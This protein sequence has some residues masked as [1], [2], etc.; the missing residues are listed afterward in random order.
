MRWTL[1]TA[2]ILSLVACNPDPPV[3]ED[4]ETLPNGQTAGETWIPVGGTGGGSGGGGDVDE[5]GIPD[6]SWIN[7]GPSDDFV[8]LPSN[9]IA[10]GD[11]STNQIVVR[12]LPG[13]TIA[14]LSLAAA[15]LDLE[16]DEANNLLYATLSGS[17]NI[18]RADLDD[19][20]AT[21]IPLPRIAS[22]IAVGNGGRVFVAM[23]GDW[24]YEGPIAVIDGPTGSVINTQDLDVPNLIAFDRPGNRLIAGHRGLSPSSLHRYSFDPATDLF[25]FLEEL[26]SA[27]S[28]GQDLTVSPD[29]QRIAFACG[30]GNAG[31]YTIVDF[32]T[33][34]LAVTFGEWN[35]DAY[36]SAARFSPNSSR[37]VATNSFSILVYDV[38][39]HVL[40]AEIDADTTG[41]SYTSL[42][43]VGY[44][45]GGDYVYA[46]TD[47]GF[48]E[49]S[50]RL[51]FYQ[52]GP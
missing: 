23:Y 17:T 8:A 42:D 41:L 19:N 48:D 4:G 26:W 1:S 18:V 46:Y 30:G 25:T 32:S 45:S 29:G 47:S 9:R 12:G 28:N 5:D 7:V 52:V 38:S 2:L 51:F 14:T 49:D 11:K 44:S 24:S 16:Y 20:S 13:S 3:Y 50:G 43:R 31:G 15:P 27:G 34:D 36:P 21:Y 39:S 22:S 6:A 10:I 40:I 37:I 35:T 33:A